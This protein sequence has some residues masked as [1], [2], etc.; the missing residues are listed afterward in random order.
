MPVDAS[1]RAA[2]IGQTSG[3]SCS[4]NSRSVDHA[5]R[6]SSTRSAPPS[7]AA[8]AIDRAHRIGQ[9]RPVMAYR[10]VAEGG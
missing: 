3:P 6:L 10:I 7:R 1:R 4:D 5:I 9:A 2:G 8:Q